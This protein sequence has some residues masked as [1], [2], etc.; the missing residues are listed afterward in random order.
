MVGN[1]HSVKQSEIV[2]SYPLAPCDEAGEEVHLP[3][4]SAG[5]ELGLSNN[6]AG[7]DVD[8]PAVVDADGT[9]HGSGARI[10][11][12]ELVDVKPRT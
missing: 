11:K 5:V 3:T 2:R 9:G 1:V 8:L 12:V 6:Q 7:K 10:A 4:G